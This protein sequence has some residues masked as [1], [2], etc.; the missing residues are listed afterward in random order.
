MKKTI[1]IALF[2]ALTS[3]FKGFGITEISDKFELDTFSQIEQQDSLTVTIFVSFT[4]DTN[5][6][7]NQPK[8]EKMECTDC[9]INELDKK[10]VKKLE[11][12]ALRVIVEMDDLDPVEKPT[13]FTQPIKMRLPVEGYLRE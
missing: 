3:A 1:L 13:K 7:V 5:G 6:K 9:D 2:I 12:E 4:V 11:K 8:V 10:A